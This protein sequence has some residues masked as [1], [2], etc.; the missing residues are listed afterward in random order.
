VLLCQGAL[1]VHELQALQCV[2]ALLEALDD[3]TNKATLNAIR[4][5]A[6]HQKGI[7]WMLLRHQVMGT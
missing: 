4:L 7:C 2:A 6:Y 3:V 5:Q 1:N